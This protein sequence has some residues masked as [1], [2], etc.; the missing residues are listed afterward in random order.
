MG[1]WIAIA[2][3]AVLV[4]WFVSAYNGFVKSKQVVSEAFSGMDVY[5]KKRYDLI[6]N[7]VETV[8]TYMQHEEGTLAKI[9][10][11]RNSAAS[12]AAAEDKMKAEGELTQTLGKL[13]ALAENYPELKADTQFTQLQ[14]E[15]GGLETD[16]AEAR[17][18]YNGAARLY[19]T[20]TQTVPNNLIAGIFHF[21]PVS[22]FEVTDAAERQAVKVDF[23][24]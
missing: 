5:L 8:K 18:Y 23:G 4:L 22:Y 11:L 17:K 24:K 13:F 6:P 14:T 15:L 1:L 9:V 21:E 12:G 16:I 19:N 3:V 2:V 10:E 20:K 7:L